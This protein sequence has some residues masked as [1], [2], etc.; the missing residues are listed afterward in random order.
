MTLLF[1]PIVGLLAHSNEILIKLGQDEKVA[2][3][4]HKYI[5]TFLPGLYISG[6]AD[7]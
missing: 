2:E 7:C 3:Y 4:S 1:V 6:L 5:M